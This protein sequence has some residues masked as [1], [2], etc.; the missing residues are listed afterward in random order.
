[1]NVTAEHGS[2]TFRS[3]LSNGERHGVVVDLPSEK[4]G[5]NLGPTALEL[6]AMSL[7]GCISTI[8][9]K[10]ATNSRVEYQSVDVDIELQQGDGPAPFDR[11]TATVRVESEADPSKLERVLDKTMN[12]CPVGQLFEAAGVTVEAEL[13]AKPEMAAA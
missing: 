5:S 1:M 13:A 6:T 2:G 4:G 11:A 9:A 8:W 7:A 3:V 10:V 12:A